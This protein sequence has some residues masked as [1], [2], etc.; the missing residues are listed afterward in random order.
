MTHSQ[1]RSTCHLCF[2]IW[3]Y[4]PCWTEQKQVISSKFRHTADEVSTC[5]CI[6][7]QAEGRRASYL[8]LIDVHANIERSAAL[9]MHA[10]LHMPCF[11]GIWCHSVSVSHDTVQNMLSLTPFAPGMSVQFHE[12]L[13]F[14]KVCACR[15]KLPLHAIWHA[16]Q[17]ADCPVVHEHFFCGNHYWQYCL[18][19]WCLMHPAPAMLITSPNMH[20]MCWSTAGMPGRSPT[21]LGKDHVGMQQVTSAPFHADISSSSE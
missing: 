15:Q 7:G 20:L 19:G 4:N 13:A 3:V 9:V 10:H 12:Q 1:V 6:A 5:C 2:A 18:H 17:A 14:A 11:M 8:C 21:S 16:R